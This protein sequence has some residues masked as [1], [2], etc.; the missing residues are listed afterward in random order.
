MKLTGSCH[1]GKVLFSL[2]SKHPYPYNLCYCSICRKT[3]GSGGFAINI[4]GDYKTLEITGKEHLSVYHA[5][6]NGDKSPAQ[7]HFCKHCGSQLWVYDPRWPDL[8]HPHAS[9]M[10]T[11]LPVPP[12]RTHLMLNYKKEWIVFCKKDND[13]EFLEYPKES[14]AEWHKRLGLEK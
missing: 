12:E 13:K 6:I 4:S 9:A 10:D 2:E 5:T 14:I 11:E 1:C 3:A 8:V 7:R